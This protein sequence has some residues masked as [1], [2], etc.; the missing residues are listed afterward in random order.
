MKRVVILGGGFGGI[1]TAKYLLQETKNRSDI[2]IVLVNKQ[3]YFLFSPMLHEVATGGLNRHHI[4]EPIR[5]VL[6]QKNF[7]FIR[8][9]V[10]SIDT[11]KKTITAKTG[12]FSYDLLIIAVGST[13]AFYNIPGA[14]EHALPLKTIEDAVAIRDRIIDSLEFAAKFHD[15]EDISKYLTF[16]II[17]GGPTG[18]ELAGEVAEFVRQA[19]KAEYPELT[20]KTTKIM[21]LHRNS[22]VM[23]FIHEC[24]RKDAM[25]ML[26]R[27]GVTL[28]LN[29][30]VTKITN[31][32]VVTGSKEAIATVNAFWTAGV[33]PVPLETHPELQD[34]L[35]FFP[36]DLYLRVKDARDVYALGDCALF[37]NED[38]G[39]PVPAL[40]Q[41]ATKQ[42][43]VLARNVMHTINNEPQEKFQFK[44]AGLLVSIGRRYA[45]AEVHGIHFKG[46]F[47]WW[48]WR[49]IYLMKLVGIANKLRVAYEWTL[50][51]FYPRDTSQL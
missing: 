41:T 23:P 6:H 38:S 24:C 8:C 37:L 39:K 43:K 28:R 51:L 50:N 12:V 33:E 48:L 29:A 40:A 3:N 27:K 22:E 11:E 44:P 36:V 20:N 16:V 5:E 30:P 34:D 14:K 49:T 18:V 26:E 7:R 35:G 47:A 31:D 4:V 9:E 10:L 45:V 15:K 25:R 17:G 42:A 19:S 1:Y 21:L 2:E 32:T 46:F 13:S